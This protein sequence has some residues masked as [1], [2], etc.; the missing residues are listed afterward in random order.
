MT[1]TTTSTTTTLDEKAT[2]PSIHETNEGKLHDSSSSSSLSHKKELNGN[3]DGLATAKDD[4]EAT[5]V[6]G[7]GEDKEPVY[8]TGL[9]FWLIIF[10]LCLAVFVLAIGL[11]LSF[12]FIV[13]H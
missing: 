1:T 7:V 13:Q 6:E 4:G 10:A 12:L 3:N 2:V 8:P 5:K 11:S 9:P